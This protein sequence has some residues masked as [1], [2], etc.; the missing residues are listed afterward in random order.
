[1][2]PRRARQQP[3]W[4]VAD[5]TGAAVQPM[6]W[7]GGCKPYTH[8]GLLRRGRVIDVR[9]QLCR[10]PSLLPDSAAEWDS[11]QFRRMRGNPCCAEP[12]ASPLRA[13][14]THNCM[15]TTIMAAAPALQVPSL[16]QHRQHKRRPPPPT[17]RK[18]SRSSRC[19]SW[20]TELTDGALLSKSTRPAARHVDRGSG[21]GPKG[22][23][24][25][26]QGVPR[27]PYL[28]GQACTLHALQRELQRP[29][30]QC[31]LMLQRSCHA[32]FSVALCAQ[33]PRS[34]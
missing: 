25:Q 6:C 30:S 33:P 29:V 34:W 5:R 3:D 9:M 12:A 20:L 15:H 13:L 17:S 10:H 4:R 28:S 32:C 21:K 27:E 31:P 19:S 8:H 14:T 11:P 23:G 2:E 22:H 24:E 18:S 1:M 26:Q 16:G 7:A